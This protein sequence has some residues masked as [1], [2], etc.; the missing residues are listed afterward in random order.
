MAVTKE[1]NNCG[2]TIPKNSGN[3]GHCGAAQLGDVQ[4]PGPELTR[5]CPHCREWNRASTPICAFCG[6]DLR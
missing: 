3:C 6:R 2:K 1:C 4:T 5:K